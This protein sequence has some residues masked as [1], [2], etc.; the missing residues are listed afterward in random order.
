M[1]E[2]NKYFTHAI[3]ILNDTIRK[4]RRTIMKEQLEVINKWT[5][6]VSE[7]DV[8]KEMVMQLAMNY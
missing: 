4:N 6:K 7:E 8:T 1:I 2:K 5:D 3:I